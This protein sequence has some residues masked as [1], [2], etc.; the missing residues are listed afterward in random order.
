MEQADG[1]ERDRFAAGVGTRDDQR[2][3]TRPPSKMNVNR[4]RVIPQQGVA[5]GFQ[6]EPVGIGD[7][8]SDRLLLQREFAPG[9][10]QVQR[11]GPLPVCSQRVGAL[12]H[13]FR[14]S[15]QH[16]PLLAAGARQQGAQLIVVLHHLQRFHVGGCPAAR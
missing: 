13:R 14:E 16:P 8:R 6:V 3:K 1:L 12:A 15:G 2:A 11:A 7:G 5:G 10:D 4:H 9:Q